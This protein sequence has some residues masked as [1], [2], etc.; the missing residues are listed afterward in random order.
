MDEN[1]YAPPRTDSDPSERRVAPQPRPQYAFL[2]PHRGGNILAW[3][4]CGFAVCFLCG[5]VAWSRGSRDL[6]AIDAG[7]MD[8]G[9]RGLTRAGL[10]L[11]KISTLIGIPVTI[12]YVVYFIWAVSQPSGYPY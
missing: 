7:A 12:I 9:G 8:P 2:R 5:I 11:G 6:A 1:P 10:I 3:G 4:I